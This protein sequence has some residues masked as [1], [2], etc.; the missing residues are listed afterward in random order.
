MRQSIQT[1]QMNGSGTKIVPLTCVDETG[2]T[3]ESLA[4]LAKPK[5]KEIFLSDSKVG[6]VFVYF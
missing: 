2:G 6:Y 1:V 3:I 5:L 4:K